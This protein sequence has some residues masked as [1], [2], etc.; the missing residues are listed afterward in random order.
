MSAANGSTTVDELAALVDR[1]RK[2]LCEAGRPWQAERLR[3]TV[4][5]TGRVSLA[6]VS[7]AGEATPEIIKALEIDPEFEAAG[8]AEGETT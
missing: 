8:R 5:P 7:G 3:A 2:A 4:D 1:A 6:T